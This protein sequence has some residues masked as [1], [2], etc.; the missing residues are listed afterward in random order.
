MTELQ[1]L[2]NPNGK[3][4]KDGSIY[5]IRNLILQQT[6]KEGNLMFLSVTRKW[7]RERQSAS[8]FT[9]CPAAYIGYDLDD[10]ACAVLYI[11]FTP[12]AVEE[13][14]AA[15]YEEETGRMITP[16]ENEAMKEEI[17]HCKHRL[18]DRYLSNDWHRRR[19]QSC[20]ISRR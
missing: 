9:S 1:G 20:Q 16:S 10:A 15:E 14:I 12:E 13:A 7:K 11:H 3:V 18:D 6:T 4:T 8:E 17:C 5:T 2:L 19:G